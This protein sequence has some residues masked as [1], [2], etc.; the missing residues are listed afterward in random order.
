MATQNNTKECNGYAQSPTVA[1]P[2]VMLFGMQE[3]ISV[4][5]DDV[6][7]NDIKIKQCKL[8][9]GCGRIPSSHILALL[10]QVFPLTL[11]TNVSFTFQI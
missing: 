4:G 8:T 6:K 5:G 3:G 9:N 2:Q 1:M 11:I 10:L 7:Q